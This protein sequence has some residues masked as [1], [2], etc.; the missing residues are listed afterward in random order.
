MPKP[1]GRGG[2]NRKKARTVDNGRRELLYPDDFQTYACVLKN[3]GDG[4]FHMACEDERE[5]TGI[6]RGKMWKRNWVRISDIVLVCL[7]DYQDDKADIVHH[8]DDGEVRKLMS[9]G[10]IDHI[11]KYRNTSEY[12]ATPAEDD[13]CIAFEETDDFSF[14]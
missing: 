13:D 6:V 11:K 2:K 9:E 5:R 10:R 12:D 1:K 3:H 4:R 7:R 14:V 8:Y